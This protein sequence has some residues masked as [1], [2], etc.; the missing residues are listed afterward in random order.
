MA[1]FISSN[2][3]SGA[4]FGRNK[5]QRV[6]K[7]WYYFD[8]EHCTIYYVKGM[9]SLARKAE[10]ILEDAYIQITADLGYEVKQRLPIVIYSSPSTFQETNIIM[11]VLG[12]GVGGFTETM[13]NRIA[14][15]FNGS[16]EEFR[17]VLVHELAHAVCFDFLYGRG[18][19][20]LISPNRI[21]RMPLWFAEG[22]SEF[23]SHPDLGWSNDADMYLRDAILNEY[24]YSL[25]YLGGFLAYKEGQSVIKYIA[26]KYGREKLGEILAKGKI[27]VTMSKALNSAIG[28]DEEELYKEWLSH[29]RKIYFPQIAKF[30]A[31]DDIGEAL[32][33]HRKDDSYFNIQPAYSPNGDRIAFFSNKHDYTDLYLL[34]PYEN[35]VEKI[36]EGERSGSEES[37]HPF[38]SSMTWSPDG[39]CLAYVIKHK[40]KDAIA[41]LDVASKDRKDLFAFDEFSAI[42]S[43]D[44]SPDGKY[45]VFSALEKDKKDLFLLSLDERKYERLTIDLYDDKHPSFSPNGEF[46]AFSSDRPAEFTDQPI[47]GEYNIYIMNLFSKDIVPLTTYG[48]MNLYPRWSPLYQNIIAFIS[49]R[50]GIYN[51][52]QGDHESGEIAPLTNILTGCA[53][54]SWKPDSS[55][56]IVS[57]VFYD[58]GYDLYLLKKLEP[59]D[60]LPITDYAAEM[61]TLATTPEES[62][63]TTGTE[64]GKLEKFVFDSNTLDESGEAP[65][66]PRRYTPKFTAD[67]VNMNVGYSTFYGFMGQTLLLFSDILGNNQILIMTDLFGNIDESN[68]YVNYS[69][70]PRRTDY[71]I[72]GFHYKDYFMDDNYNIFSDR[73]Y[74]G[75]AYAGYPF[76]QFSRAGFE[77]L[78]LAV[79][80]KYYEYLFTETRTL[81]LQIRANL[82]NDYTLWGYTGPVNGGRSCLTVEAVPP[83]SDGSLEYIAGELDVR[84][85]AK[86]T[87]GYSMATRLAAG[88]SVGSNPKLYYLGGM[89]NWFNY[90]I[91]RDNVYSLRDMYFSSMVLP[92]R[93]FKYFEL[94]GTKYFLANLEFRYPFI[95][96]LALG[97][98]PIALSN[99]NGALFI[100]IGAVAD[101]QWRQFRWINDSR[102]Q[103][104]KMGFGLGT[105]M[106]VGYFVLNWDVAWQTDLSGYSHPI[107]YF[108]LG[109]EF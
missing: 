77:A 55:S 64:T 1:I 95:E 40:G 94:S 47:F 24:V 2:L 41:I 6:Y 78:F 65:R 12:E 4:S 74:G 91:G 80:R 31:P 99:I 35:K 106:N 27:F 45:I 25:E 8:T 61:E 5:V 54:F 33:N 92:L 66:G 18:P 76:S 87:R 22:I 36:A 11:E 30:S 26:E 84:R 93:G 21:F 82:V 88:L 53:T 43:P 19:V 39:E 62:A 15:P 79:D 50:N 14:V 48:G 90:N 57:S 29:V 17:H 28:K 103:D 10:T 104:V 85:Y 7:H 89:N 38:Y 63:E 83:L 72:I 86:F 51:I 96:R 49:D 34:Y 3:L 23:E 59:M 44:W 69:Y 52:Y 101:D 60:N 81:N 102:L 70:L 42:T 107:H 32:T 9:E 56:D 16:Y 73:V 58:G 20:S 100:D 97:F 98:P 71:S 37:F 108:A 105:R 68:V 75:G 109:G 67:L 46:I 13:K